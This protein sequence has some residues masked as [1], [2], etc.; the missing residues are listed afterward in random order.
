MSSLYVKLPMY[1]KYM[2]REQLLEYFPEGTETKVITSG[3]NK[4]KTHE[5]PFYTN[6]F[7]YYE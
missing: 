1:C 2:T 4:G 6:A 7:S 5:V 3:K